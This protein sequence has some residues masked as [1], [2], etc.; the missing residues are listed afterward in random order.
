MEMAERL[1]TTHSVEETQHLG[2]ELGKRLIPGSIL[3]LFGDLGSGKT[4]FIQGL[5]HGMKVPSDC[6]VNSPT[7]T[8]INEY[9]ARLPFYHVDLFRLKDGADFEDIGLFELFSPANV[10]AIEWSERLHESELPDNYCKIHISVKNEFIRTLHIIACG[11]KMM[12]LV[13]DM[14]VIDGH[15]PI[16]R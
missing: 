16:K 1:Y 8:I 12:D 6:Y 11:L 10:V 4:V 3:L 9:P 13:K 5:A 14:P 15:H 7:Y 2:R